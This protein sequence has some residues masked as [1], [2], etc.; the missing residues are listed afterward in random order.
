MQ[1][2]SRKQLGKHVPTCNNI[3][4][5]FLCGLYHATERSVFYVVCTT[6]QYSAVFYVHG[7]YREDIRFSVVQF[8]VSC[9]Y[10]IATGGLLLKKN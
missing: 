10:D 8:K 4:T 3:G 2:I 5:C 7:P 6:Q 1:P 9:R